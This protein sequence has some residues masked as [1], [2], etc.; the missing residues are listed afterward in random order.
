MPRRKYEW[1]SAKFERYMKEGRGRGSGKDYKPWLTIQDVRT[2]PEDIVKLNLLPQENATITARGLKPKG[3][4]MYYTCDRAEREQW[5]E[6]ARSNLLSKSEK[7]ITIAYDIRNPNF[8]YL[9]SPDGKN[10]EKCGSC[11]PFMEN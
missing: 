1:N 9:P 3:K 10:F 5:F 7:T 11:V 2:F 6:R 4:D 8:I